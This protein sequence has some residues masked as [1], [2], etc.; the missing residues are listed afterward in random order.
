MS[1]KRRLIFYDRQFKRLVTI[2][3]D[4]LLN[5][6]H[7]IHCCIVSG[8]TLEQM[9][10]KQIVCTQSELICLFEDLNLVNIYHLKTLQLKRSSLNGPTS[11]TNRN[12]RPNVKCLCLDSFD[13]LYST[14]GKTLFKL[15]YSNKFE[16]SKKLSPSLKKGARQFLCH[17]I[18]WMS[19]LTNGKIVLLTDSLQMESSNLYFL[20]PVLI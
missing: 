15:D 14:N 6:R 19:I 20:R 2:Q 17:N 16:K 12:M 7:L 8:L 9:F 4:L 1:Q 13:S 3:V 10:V 11:S 5:T 18:A